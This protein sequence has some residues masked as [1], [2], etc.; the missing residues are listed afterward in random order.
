MTTEGPRPK[1]L[2]APRPKSL[3]A[4]RPKSAEGPRPKDAALAL[5]QD[6]LQFTYA[7][8]SGAGG[9]NVNKVSSKAI[10]RWNPGSS[11]ALSPGMRERFFARFA[12]KLTNE[13]E[14]LITS[15][16]HRD[17]GR[18]A[19]DCIEKLKEMIASIA[20]PPKKRKATK[21][22]F[23]SKVRRLNTKR[24]QSEKKQGRRDRG[25]D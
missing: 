14:L 17:Q 20:T 21:P 12:S 22:T 4:P 2:S 23:G 15:D 25:D 24:A 3:S 5:A 18:N 8:S 11:R 19:A 10:L 9:Q 1:N 16:R 7:R 6:E 13:G